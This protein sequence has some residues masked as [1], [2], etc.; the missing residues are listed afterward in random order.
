MDFGYTC[1]SKPPQ[2]RLPKAEAKV[3]FWVGVLEKNLSLI[4]PKVILSS[5]EDAYI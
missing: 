4:L 3:L 2:L 5:T 1:T